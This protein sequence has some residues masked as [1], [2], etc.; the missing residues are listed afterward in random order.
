MKV[1]K[2]IAEKCIL[3]ITEKC[4]ILL[5]E[6]ED[7]TFQKIFIIYWMKKNIYWRLNEEILVEFKTL[8]LLKIF[9][10]INSC[11]Y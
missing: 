3:G 1:T 8:Y 11:H 6:I 7:E 4:Y 10:A 5:K 9:V 2:V